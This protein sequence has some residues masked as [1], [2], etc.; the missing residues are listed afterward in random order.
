M[1]VLVI[2]VEISQDVKLCWYLYFCGIGI[3]IG[4]E[5]LCEEERE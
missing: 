5:G 2:M 4:S 1:L 3:N